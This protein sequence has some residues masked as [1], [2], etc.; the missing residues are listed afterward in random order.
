MVVSVMHIAIVFSQVAAVKFTVYTPIIN[1]EEKSVYL[2][3][4]FNYWH[5][6]DSLY[7]MKEIGTGIYSITI[8]VFENR[9]YTYKYTLGT[10]KKVEVALNDSDIANRKFISLNNKSLIDTVKKWKQAA[11]KRD[12][13]EQLKRLNL[14]K[15][16]LMAKLKPELAH[17]QELLKLYVQN[18]LRPIPDK[19]Q[20][21]QLDEQAI[22]RIGNIYR[23][24]TGLLWNIA[25]SLSEQQKQQISK[26]VNQPNQADAL[27]SFLSALNEAVR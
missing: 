10:W 12:S 5:E 2:A 25:A 16:S 24:I 1:S 26:S 4:S 9:E 15:D 8:P 7:R 27:N 20:H 11:P 19:T 14:M 22:G 6:K 13:S 18:M 17:I 21:Q 23:Q 3:G